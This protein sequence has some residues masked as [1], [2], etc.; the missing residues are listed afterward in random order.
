VYVF[1]HLTNAWK[2][3]MNV[4]GANLKKEAIGNNTGKPAMPTE[5]R[6]GQNYPN[7]FNPTTTIEYQIPEA[8]FV[9]LKIYDIQGHLVKTLVSQNLDAG[10]YKAYWN[11]SGF[12]SGVYFYRLTSEAFTETKR[13]L[14]LK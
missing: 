12:A 3:S 9:T 10:Y 13:L 8:K 1:N 11:A 5:Y 7:P 4:M 2:F 6:L 14:L